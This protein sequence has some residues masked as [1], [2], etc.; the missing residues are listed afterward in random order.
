MAT[1]PTKPPMETL[2]ER[3]NRLAAQWRAETAHLSSSTAIANHPAYQE[4][5]ALGPPT[6]PLILRELEKRRDH[7]FR[8]LTAITGANPITSESRGRIDQMAKAWLQWGKD[9]GYQW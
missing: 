3:F 7:W 5:I 1:V 6:V 2:E 9:R 4:I 8:A